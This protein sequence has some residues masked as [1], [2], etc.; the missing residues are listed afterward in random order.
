MHFKS[1]YFLC[2]LASLGSFG[3][4]VFLFRLKMCEL[5]QKQNKR[6]PFVSTGDE[7]CLRWAFYFTISLCIMVMLGFH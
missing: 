3:L 7:F 5:V 4:F 2:K 6:T 1:E